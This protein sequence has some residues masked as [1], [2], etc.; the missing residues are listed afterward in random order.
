MTKGKFALGALF[1]AAAGLVTGLLTA[2][3]SGKE[4]RADLKVK[5]DDI[6][7]DA[8]R[9][10]K[11]AADKVGTVANEAKDKAEGTIEDAKEKAADFKTRTER[12]L[13]G[14]KKGFKSKK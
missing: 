11:Q 2:P 12:V 1:G 13:E 8:A 7:S 5:A 3:K 14:A 9:K 10:S 6:K 4:T